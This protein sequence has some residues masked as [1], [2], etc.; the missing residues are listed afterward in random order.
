MASG[1]PVRR[2]APAAWWLLGALACGCRPAGGAAGESAENTWDPKRGLHFSREVLAGL[3][4]TP[5]EVTERSV[6]VVLRAGARVTTTLGRSTAT[7]QVSRAEARA[8]RR[9]REVRLRGA[10]EAA[11]VRGVV[12]GVDAGLERA[13]GSVEVVIAA[14][15]PLDGFAVAELSAGTVRGLFVPRAAVLDRNGARFVY[16][17]NERC[18]QRVEIRTGV[19]TDEWTQVTD[20]LVEGDRVMTGDVIALWI[21]EL[22]ASTSGGGRCCPI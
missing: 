9:G 18:F 8:W 20:G 19:E 13:T 11:V 6:A 1:L 16:V 4:V 17:E 15:A 7:V 14:D 22:R 10:S 21:S 12:T 5:R 3:A 2:S